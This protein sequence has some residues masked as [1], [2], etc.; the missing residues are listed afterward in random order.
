M[1]NC[2]FKGSFKIVEALHFNILQM[3]KKML[4]SRK[5]PF[6]TLTIINNLKKDFKKSKY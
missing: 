3:G 1:S 4:I 5:S 2:L 6:K